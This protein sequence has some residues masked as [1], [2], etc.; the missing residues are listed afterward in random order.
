MIHFRKFQ[1]EDNEIEFV[2]SGSM[3]KKPDENEA[4]KKEDDNLSKVDIASD[5]TL[6]VGKN[7]VGKTTIITA[8]EKLVGA[9]GNSFCENDFNFTYLKRILGEYNPD[10]YELPFI[11]FEITVGLEDDLENDII[12]NLIPFINVE[13]VEEVGTPEIKIGVKYE[14]RDENSYKE[15]LRQ[16]MSDVHSSNLT[17]EIKE[18]NVSEYLELLGQT[19]YKLNFYKITEEENKDA[20]YEK[21]EKDFKLSN[22]MDITCIKANHLKNENC[23]REAFNKIIRF[24]YNKIFKDDDK[25]KVR[26]KL[27]EINSGMSEV[28]QECQTKPLK[29][30]LKQIVSGENVEVNLEADLTFEK[31][32]KDLIKYEYIEGGVPI[33]ENQF[34]L[35]YTNLIMIIAT[36]IDYIERYPENQRNSRINLISIEEP[37]TFMHPQMQELFIKNINEAIHILLKKKNKD[38]NSQI[39]ITTHSSHILNSKI[40]S[41]NTF[42]NIC[43]LY[44]RKYRTHIVNLTNEK[45][46]PEEER[47]NKKFQFL[48]KHVKYKASELFFSDAIIFVEGFSEDTLLPYYLEK[49][50][51]LSKSYISIFNVNGAHAYIYKKLI[52]TLKIP[53][54]IITDLDIKRSDDEKKEFNQIGNIEGK[55]TTNKTIKFFN[56]DKKEIPNE[57]HIEDGNIY[58]AYQGKVENYYA[59]SFEEAFILTNYNNEYLNS[60]LK[61]LKPDIY[62]KIVGKEEYSKNIENSYKWQQKLSDVKGEFASTL[63]F[64]LIANKERNKEQNQSE[65]KLP[66]YIEDGFIWLEERL[67]ERGNNG[68]TKNQE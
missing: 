27:K 48:K 51:V 57:E 49:R 44:E 66:K 59:T 3:K 9:S 8:L 21:L 14:V 4:S 11:G 20:Q 17:S 43:Y 31:L 50:D 25:K 12:S 46:N 5:T 22:L 33:P 64:E 55:E 62:G 65:S 7:N 60:V 41:D 2:T 35:G 61:Q 6:I 13:D 38:I 26:H 54:L 37:E 15:K 10:K 47:G 40:H 67:R 42:D 52:Q 58:L 18:I 28:I 23:I 34:G 68:I 1:T 30:S 29:D 45:V 32:V 16:M 53:T 56:K 24:Q 19:D 39:I 36:I 63:L